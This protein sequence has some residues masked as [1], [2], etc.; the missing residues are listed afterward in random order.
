MNQVDILKATTQLKDVY[1]RAIYV[2]MYNQF[3]INHN[4]EEIRIH[5]DIITILNNT[6]NLDKAHLMNNN[7]S[8]HPSV[9]KLLDMK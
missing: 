1:D 3:I 4:S 2:K 7:V 6:N 5:E 9:Q 8:K